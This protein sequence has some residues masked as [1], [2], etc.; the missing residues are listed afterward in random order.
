MAGKLKLDW[1]KDHGGVGDNVRNPEPKA[2]KP[3]PPGPGPGPNGIATAVVNSDNPKVGTALVTYTSQASCPN[4]GNNASGY[5]CPL[6]GDGCY[7]EEKGKHIRFTT[8]RLN[9]NAGQSYG[10]T[11]ANFTPEEVAEEEATCLNNSYKYWS[12]H[13]VN[14]FVRLH[15]VGDCVTAKAARMV[16]DAVQQYVTSS[17][18]VKNVWNYTHAWR[19]VPRS[20]W[21]S[22]ISV[23]AS[24]DTIEDLPKAHA[25]GYACAIVMSREDI[26]YL[27][28]QQNVKFGKEF[29]LPNGFKIKPC[30]YEIAKLIPGAVGKQCIDCKWCMLDDTYRDQKVVIAFAAHTK[31][32]ER[33]AKDLID[34]DVEGLKEVS[35]N[36]ASHHPDYRSS[37]DESLAQWIERKRA[38]NPRRS[39]QAGK[40]YHGFFSTWEEAQ[41]T[42]NNL[43]ATGQYVSAGVDHEPTGFRVFTRSSSRRSNPEDTAA[44]MYETFHGKTSEEILE[45]GETVHFHANLAVLGELVEFKIA[46][47]TGKDAEIDFSKSQC[48]LCSNETGTQLYVVGGDQSLDLAKL[49][50]KGDQL[51]KD[52]ITLGVLYELTYQTQKGFDK[53]KLTDYFHELGEETGCQPVAVYDR[54]N[55]FILISGGSY[56]I[57]DRGIVD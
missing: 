16:S 52:L 26:E 23:L 29:M 6:L 14:N 28:G 33:V 12:R 30:Q 40:Q 8:E 51:D 9:K 22:N 7:A 37:G 10:S 19:S 46:T 20:A 54:L 44:E 36:P 57:E 18:G 25:K 31:E 48:M 43:M 50:F 2:K 11:E 32:S 24:C 4:G 27:G 47:V 34:I 17:S 49:G 35:S 13:K 1:G 53:F 21:S 56:K 55:D 39:T 3:K 41:D 38:G 42:A 15:G 45:V 5:R